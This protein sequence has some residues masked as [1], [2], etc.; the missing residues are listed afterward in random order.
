MRVRLHQR[1]RTADD[2]ERMLP[3]SSS[4]EAKRPAVRIKLAF[5]TRMKR[6][7]SPLIQAGNDE[8]CDCAE[9]KCLEEVAMESQQHTRCFHFR[10]PLRICEKPSPT[11]ELTGVAAGIGDVPTAN[12]S[13]FRNPENP[14]RLSVRLPICSKVRVQD[15]QQPADHNFVSQRKCDRYRPKNQKHQNESNAPP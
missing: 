7:P 8:R 3:H 4:P 1:F 11:R 6:L 10:C 2:S 12:L 14:A 9:N 5:R 13:L 15:A